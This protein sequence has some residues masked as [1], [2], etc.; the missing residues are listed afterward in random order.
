MKCIKWIIEYLCLTFFF[1]KHTHTQYKMKQAFSKRVI[2]CH[3]CVSEEWCNSLTE[4]NL[5]ELYATLTR[6]PVHFHL[7]KAFIWVTLGY[8][9]Q[10][11]YFWYWYVW[12]QLLLFTFDHPLLVFMCIYYLWYK[13]ALDKKWEVFICF[14]EFV[15][16]I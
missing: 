15:Y 8:Y 12:S 11:C 7:S 3:L 10:F 1:V 6:R 13:S 2:Q 16:N 4:L 14:F 9:L 5:S